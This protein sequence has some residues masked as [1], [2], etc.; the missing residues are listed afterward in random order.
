MSDFLQHIGRCVRLPAVDE[1]DIPGREPVLL[2]KR[3]R[4]RPEQ[5]NTRAWREIALIRASCPG[6]SLHGA[7]VRIASL[8]KSERYLEGEA[9]LAT[10]ASLVSRWTRR[11][12]A[13]R[14]SI[15]LHEARVWLMTG[16]P[17][18][19]YLEWGLPVF[20]PTMSTAG[21]NLSPTRTASWIGGVWA[22]QAVDEIGLS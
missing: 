11:H 6:L 4:G 10:E 20:I 2:L 9:Y 14:L 8:V 1:S 15:D 22:W 19:W 3:R 16:A 7:A 21:F 13:R 17:S 18:V 12:H 5:D